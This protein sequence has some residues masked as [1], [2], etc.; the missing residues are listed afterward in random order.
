MYRVRGAKKT[1]QTFVQNTLV[2]VLWTSEWF[3]R[4]SFL[5]DVR[6]VETSVNL[7]QNSITTIKHD[8][9]RAMVC[10]YFASSGSGN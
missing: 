6:A 9:G 1:R 7:T 5:E 8:G 10:R 3:E 2:V 4:I